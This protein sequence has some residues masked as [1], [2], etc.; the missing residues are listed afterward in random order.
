MGASVSSSAR[1]LAQRVAPGAQRKLKPFSP[2]EIEALNR[3]A[4]QD[5]ARMRE[6]PSMDELNAKDSTLDGFLSKLGGAI[7]GRDLS[8]EEPPQASPSGRPQMPPARPPQALRAAAMASWKSTVSA[9]DKPGRL[10]SYLIREVLEARTAA[11]A[12]Q[13]VLDLE[14]YVRMY[15][16][17][18]AKLLTLMEHACMPAVGKVATFGHQ[19]AFA[20]APVWWLRDGG[21]GARFLSEPEELRR[22]LMG[23]PV[24]AGGPEGDGDGAPA[25]AGIFGGGRNGV[26]DAAA[27]AGVGAQAAGEAAQGSERDGKGAKGAGGGNAG[28]A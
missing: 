15:G 20:R 14:P 10:Q 4:E 19:Y 25:T 8:P 9:E 2:E 21:S 16:A 26:L 7:A 17:D 6:L 11:A 5:Q 1:Q 24:T 3:M 13:K 27:A 28:K 12:E 23:N 18:R 22:R